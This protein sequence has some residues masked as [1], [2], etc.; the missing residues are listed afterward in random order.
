M[1]SCLVFIVALCL[2]SYSLT[3]QTRYFSD[4]PDGVDPKVIGS[5]LAEHFLASPHQGTPITYQEVCAWHGAF[6]VATATNDSA[7]REKLEARLHTV[8]LTKNT[9]TSTSSVRFRSR[10]RRSNMRPRSSNS[11]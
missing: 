3:A 11:G 8:M 2:L 10:Y 4:W 7:L 5:Q 9:S 6:A 1:R